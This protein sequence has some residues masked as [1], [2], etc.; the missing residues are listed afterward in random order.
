MMLDS[1]E[2]PKKPV[3]NEFQ[4]TIELLHMMRCPV[5]R[6]KLSVAD[7]QLIRQVNERI[8]SGWLRDRSG[9]EILQ[10]LDGGLVNDDGSLLFPIRR[11]IVTLVKDQAIL[12]NK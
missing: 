2:N 10:E 1:V 8:Q 12:V 4:L 9:N 6:S 3:P 5:S 7:A 11:G